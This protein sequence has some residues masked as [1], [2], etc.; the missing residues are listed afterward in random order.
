MKKPEVIQLLKEHLQ[1]A[2][3]I[4]L[5]TLPPYLCAYWSIHGDS[6][7]ATSVK[8]FILSIVQEE[9][10]H[11]AMACNILNAIGGSPVLNNPS[12]HPSFPCPLPGHSKTNNAFTVE[13]N[14]CCPASLS[15]FLRIEL[16]EELYGAKHHHDGWCTIAEF[17]DTITALLKSETL[18][19]ADFNHGRQVGNQ[20]NPAKGV[21]YE[22]QSR[23][24]ALKALEEI[25]DQGEGHSGKMYDKDHQLTHYWKFQAVYDLMQNEIWDFKSDVYDMA[26]N[27]DESYFS[28]EAKKANEQFNLAWSELLDSMHTAFNS[29]TPALDKSID[30]MFRLKKPAVELM[31][32][33][34][35]GKTGNAGPTFNYIPRKVLY[36]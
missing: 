6:A 11:M 5:S 1:V 14:K 10:L 31:Q 16:P 36:Y 9:M 29:E 25:I 18:V 4:E 12:L 23:A 24:D 15:T 28:D 27:P 8:K 7:H 19:D 20:F 35:I 17:Y 34:L 33:P 13:L 3:M 2:M 32:I 22:V 26:A 30:L 21:L